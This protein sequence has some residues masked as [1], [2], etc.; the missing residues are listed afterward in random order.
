M[1]KLETGKLAIVRRVGI[2][3]ITLDGKP[4]GRVTYAS[5]AAPGQIEEA[6]VTFYPDAPTRG[7]IGF[8]FRPAA[9]LLDTV[10]EIIEEARGDA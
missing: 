1:P 6:A 7:V 8:G 9:G 5:Y 4:I 2:D 10:R 3:E